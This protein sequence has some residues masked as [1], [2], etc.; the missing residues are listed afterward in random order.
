MDNL[1]INNLDACP[2]NRAPLA[3]LA[4]TPE[5]GDAPLDVS[6]NGSGS[7]DPD[8]GDRVVSYSFNFGD[9]STEVT[10]ASPSISHTYTEPG[11][12]TAKLK[13]VDTSGL[14]SV[15]VSKLI[16]VNEVVQEAIAPFIFIE[17]TNVKLNNFI[18][19]ELITVTGFAGALP[20]SATPGL[21]FSING[22]PFTTTPGEILAGQTLA[23]R[24]VSANAEITA[25]E[26]TLTVGSGASAYSTVFRTVTTTL[27]HVPAPF[28]FGKI[29][30]VTAGSIVESGVQTLTAYDDAIVVPGAGV[31]YRINAGAWMT[32]RSKILSGQTLQVRHTASSASLGYTKSSI[33]VGGVKG[34]FT[35]RTRK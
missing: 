25:T 3:V 26:S 24:H 15:E 7:S 33:T 30:N 20:V 11:S 13:V 18:T 16:T 23:V 5:S 14:P 19:S 31:S 35:T 1:V 9:G 10:Q 29:E 8:A 21:Q 22:A 27:D 4:A 34:S 32:A 28:D 2:A 17:R 12:Y 6:L